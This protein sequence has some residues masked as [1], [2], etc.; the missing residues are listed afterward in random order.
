MSTTRAAEDHAGLG[1]P[2]SRRVGIGKIVVLSLG[3]GLAAAV[4]LPFIPWP[5]VD[6]NFATAT[7]LLGFALG[8]ALLAALSVGLSSQPQRWA[9][10]PALFMGIS[11]LLLLVLPDALLDALD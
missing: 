11:A 9:Y 10:A 6:A 7:V 2:R 1:E 4:L 5:S 8:W 3:V